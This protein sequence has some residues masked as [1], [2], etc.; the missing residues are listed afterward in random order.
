MQYLERFGLFEANVF[1]GF[2]LFWVC[3]LMV[4]CTYCKP[5][6][7]KASAKWNV[8]LQSSSSSSDH[9]VRVAGG[10]AIRAGHW[11][12][13]GRLSCGEKI[14]HC[15]LQGKNLSLLSSVAHDPFLQEEGT[16]FKAPHWSFTICRTVNQIQ[17][18]SCR[19]LIIGF[20]LVS[21]SS[22]F[23]ESSSG[24]NC[25]PNHLQHLIKINNCRKLF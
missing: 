5:L 21:I 10:C 14:P 22:I 3:I 4:D 6:W 7:Q 23:N 2:L 25:Q 17:F 20:Q 19:L 12:A 1:T 13:D 24:P 11:L 15:C 18:K 9:A 16:Y 8:M